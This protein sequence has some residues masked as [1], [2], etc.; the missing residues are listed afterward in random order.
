[1]LKSQILLQNVPCVDEISDNAAEATSG[2]ISMSQQWKNTTLSQNNCL[3]KAKAIFP[4]SGLGKN[5][6]TVGGRSVF[7]LTNDN[8]YIGTARCI[9]S[10]DVVFFAVAG[11]SRNQ[12]SN[13]RAELFSRFV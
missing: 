12:A 2:G 3:D 7:G 11:P 6:Q 8:Q 4:E 10:K 9:D 13:L 1:M 5:V